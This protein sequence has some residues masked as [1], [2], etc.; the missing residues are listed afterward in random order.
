MNRRET[1]PSA[2]I[3]F[4]VK[5]ARAVAVLLAGPVESPRLLERRDVQL[6]D[7]VMPETKAPYHAAL[8]LSE[9]AG[10]RVVQRAR[11]AV[12]A[13]ANRAVHELE[14][15]LRAGGFKLHG[16]GL[17]VGSDRDPAKLGNA[18]IRAHASE[19]R[20]YREVLEA[21]AAGRHARSTILVESEAYAKAGTVLGRSPDDLKEALAQL[22]RAA[23]R[24]WGAEEKMAT[25]AAWVALA[26]ES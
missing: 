25:L 14:S 8:E 24:P 20:F 4:R 17:V 21:G 18:H 26:G 19:G 6:W 11:D 3:G 16:V 7:P 23:G 5:T 2:T 15:K 22:G 1:E 10:A 9:E 12:Q 13:I